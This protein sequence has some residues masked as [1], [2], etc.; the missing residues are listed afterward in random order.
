[1]GAAYDPGLSE[2]LPGHSVS[3]PG[4][5]GIR[6]TDVHSTQEGIVTLLGV[7]SFSRGIAECLGSTKDGEKACSRGDAGGSLTGCEPWVGLEEQVV[8]RRDTN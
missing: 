4:Q 3:A 6:A 7:K 8:T 1:M 2:P 5:P